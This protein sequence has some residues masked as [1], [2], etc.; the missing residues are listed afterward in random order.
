[1]S[2]TTLIDQLG[3]DF[4]HWRTLQQPRSHDDI[5]RLERVKNWKPAWNSADVAK[6]R[7]TIAEFENRWSAIDPGSVDKLNVD[8]ES[9]VDYQL[10]GSAI[11]RVYW[12]LDYLKI[13]QQQPRF[14][15]DQSIGVL[16]DLLLPLK[17]D[18]N[19]I[20]EVILLHMPVLL[21]NYWLILK[22]NS[23]L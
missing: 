14:Y 4:W 1:M 15:I 10:I 7:I 20:E 19:K 22:I 21:L 6:Y 12:E 2:A 5:P 9:W 17:I 11:K 13:W 23:S 18:N 16:F 3:H 8:K